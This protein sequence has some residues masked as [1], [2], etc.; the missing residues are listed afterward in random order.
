[1][2]GLFL[3]QWPYEVLDG[4]QEMPDDTMLHGAVELMLSY[5]GPSLPLRPRFSMKYYDMVVQVVDHMAATIPLPAVYE[6]KRRQTHLHNLRSWAFQRAIVEAQ[7]LLN[8]LC[9]QAGIEMPVDGTGAILLL[10]VLRATRQLTETEQPLTHELHGALQEG[11]VH[12]ER[13]VSPEP[14]GLTAKLARAHIGPEVWQSA[15]W[16]VFVSW[17]DRKLSAETEVG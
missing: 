2:D 17:L 13:L 11:L 8:K 4:C 15:P 7:D 5:E 9:D 3:D 6:A 12:L 10:R 14:T 16:E 1:M